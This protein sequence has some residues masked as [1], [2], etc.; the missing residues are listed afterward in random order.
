MSALSNVLH[1]KSL[2]TCAELVSVLSEAFGVSSVVVSKAYRLDSFHCK[3]MK[4][5]RIE[6]FNHCLFQYLLVPESHSSDS[7]T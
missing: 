6:E 2:T 1:K 5:A 4:W 7:T 3:A